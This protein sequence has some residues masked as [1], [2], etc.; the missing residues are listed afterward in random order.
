MGPLNNL[1]DY[2]KVLF[3][4]DKDRCFRRTNTFMSFP[5]VIRKIVFIY[6]DEFQMN[7]IRTWELK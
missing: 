5:I 3:L 6:P 4:T 2:L 1:L 7:I